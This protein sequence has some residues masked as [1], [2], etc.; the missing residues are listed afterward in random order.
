[1]IIG[2]FL[3]YVKNYQATTYIPLSNGKAFSGIVGPNGAGKS[4]ILESINIFFNGG[5]HDGFINNNS[6]SNRGVPTI[7]IL[8]LFSKEQAVKVFDETDWGSFSEKN[9]S[10]I[11][12]SEKI[13]SNLNRDLSSISPSQKGYIK[14]LKMHLMFLSRE[15][16][17]DDTVIVSA[18]ISVEK[19]GS[20]LKKHTLLL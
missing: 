17:F 7:C 15:V 5:F 2:A 18:G 14:S 10:I 4:T 6:V 9:K 8:F 3:R 11:E 13:K 16:D 1:M 20:P 12:N 19:K